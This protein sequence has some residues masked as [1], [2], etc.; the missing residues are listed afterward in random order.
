M[1]FFSYKNL[2]VSAALLLLGL[3]PHQTLAQ[4]DFNPAFIISDP[5]LFDYT[6]WTR[7]DIQQFLNG[8]GS[9]LKNYQSTNTSG[10]SMMAADIIHEAAQR[11]QINPKYILV[12]LQKEQSLI[13]D[14]T[15]SQKQLDWAAGYS[16]CDSCSMEDPKI[17][18]FKGFGKQVDNAAGIMRWYFQN[19]D[20][21]YIKKKDV[22]TTIDNTE[23]IPGSWATAFLYTYTPHLHGNRNFWRI[24]DTWFAQVYPN[25]TLLVSDTTKDYWIIKDGSRRRFKNMTALITRADPKN[26]IKVTEIDLS[27]YQIG[28]EISFPNYSILRTPSQTYLLDNDTLRPFASNEVVAKIGYNP[29]EI[30]PINDNDIIGYAIGVVITTA[31]AAPQGVIYQI[32]DL[33][34]AY[35]LLKDNIFYPITDKNIIAVNYK[36][37][38]IEKHK[39]KELNEYPVADLPIV[40]KDGTLLKDITNLQTYVIDRGKK[41]PIAD[42][43]TFIALGYKRTNVVAVESLTILNVPSGE[44]L[45]MNASLLSSKDKFLGDSAAAVPDLYAKNKLASYLVAEYPSGRILSGK[46]I[47][48]RRS[49]ASLTKLLVGY[50]AVRQGFIATKTTVYNKTKHD[51]GSNPLGFKDGDTIK[52]KDLLYAM[53]VSSDNNA[54]KM[55]AQSTKMDENSLVSKIN[56]RLDEWGADN[57]SIHEVTGLDAD[58]KSTSRDLLKIF[59]RVLSDKTLAD[60]LA[61]ST[62]TF[63]KIN[64]KKKTESRLLVNSNQIIKNVPLAK[65]SYRI[66]ATKTGFTTEAQGT[67]IMLIEVKKT[68]KQYVIVTLGNPDY[69]K[70]FEEPHKIANWISTTK[71][72][73]Q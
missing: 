70:R 10:T 63:K 68:K 57:T 7:N 3:V 35:Y 14:D 49:I 47:D 55:V 46:N 13:T 58:D 32:T 1:Q 29:E 18:K 40:F 16:V 72:P 69:A 48:T 31:S 33:K 21:G 71:L 19:L 53:Y 2:I 11:Y 6:S 36:D 4:A 24:W 45:F 12:T 15:P 42:D 22:A 9:F 56:H 52:N 28:P 67:L 62:F 66:L 23:V 50:E 60:A 38:A 43:D 41:R 8:R 30:I 5:E 73:S 37:F 34:N 54:A 65:R 39:A 44:P 20:K 51:S 25:G 59:T 26:A 61:Q 64:A 17:Q 27:N